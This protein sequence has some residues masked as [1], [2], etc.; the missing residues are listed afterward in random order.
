MLYGPWE[1]FKRVLSDEIKGLQL[2][3]SFAINGQVRGTE[4]IHLFEVVVSSSLMAHRQ[5]AFWEWGTVTVDPV[6][7]QGTDES[8]LLPSC[9]LA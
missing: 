5:N 2:W 9:P 1:F 7:G 3:Q 4:M 8:N 6:Q